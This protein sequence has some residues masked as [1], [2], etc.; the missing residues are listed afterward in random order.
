[1]AY[2]VKWTTSG[3]PDKNVL[4]AMKARRAAILATDAPAQAR[5]EAS[6]NALKPGWLAAEY[7]DWAAAGYPALP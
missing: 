5:A 7:A 4:Q 3:F 6:L 1:M 2:P